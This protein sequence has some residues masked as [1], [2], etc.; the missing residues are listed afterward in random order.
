M[1]VPV[2]VERGG[3]A[4]RAVGACKVARSGKVGGVAALPG[5]PDLNDI[6]ITL[7]AVHLELSSPYTWSLTPVINPL[8][9][10]HSG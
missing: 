6:I 7:S 8:H 3:R 10:R 9:R 4:V 2:V 1:Y 5:K